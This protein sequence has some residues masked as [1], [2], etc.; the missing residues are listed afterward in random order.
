MKT[1]ETAQVA[2]V[3]ISKYL[4]SAP[5]NNDLEMLLFTLL[6]SLARHTFDSL[7]FLVSIFWTFPVSE[8]IF[9]HTQ[10]DLGMDRKLMN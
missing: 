10:V 8:D 7:L 1:K 5:M 2:A 9:M 6:T 3:K 4:H